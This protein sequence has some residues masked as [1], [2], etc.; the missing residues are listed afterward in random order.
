MGI[1]AIKNIEKRFAAWALKFLDKNQNQSAIDSDTNG[2]GYAD[3]FS[4]AFNIDVNAPAI[5]PNLPKQAVDG[6][7]MLIQMTLTNDPDL[8]IP[9]LILCNFLYSS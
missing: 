2:D 8:V 4:Y 6:D 3:I 9:N 1:R 7:D 5:S